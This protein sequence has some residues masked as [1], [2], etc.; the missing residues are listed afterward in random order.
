MNKNAITTLKVGGV[1]AYPTDTAYA[2]GADPENNTALSKVFAIKGRKKDKS[3]TL[4]ASDI[5]MVRRYAKLDVLSK[6]FADHFWPGP[7]TLVLEPTEFAKKVFSKRVFQNGKLAIRVPDN[8]IARSLSASFNKPITA[9]SANISRNPMCWSYSSVEMEFSGRTQKPDLL[10]KSKR[11]K[12]T[13]PSTIIEVKNGK[14]ILR[15][16][17]I[18][19]FESLGT[20]ASRQ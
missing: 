13:K 18:I 16:D 19:P 8:N 10:V 12:R 2:L 17:G 15:R 9:T 4:I 7:L 20:L 6:R 1:I 3:L 5:A 11:L 14:I